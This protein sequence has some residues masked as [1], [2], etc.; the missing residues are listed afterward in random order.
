MTPQTGAPQFLVLTPP[1]TQH[2]QAALHHSGTA[3]SETRTYQLSFIAA[4]KIQFDSHVNLLGVLLPQKSLSILGM[5]NMSVSHWG[6]ANAWDSMCSITH[7]HHSGDFSRSPQLYSLR[8]AACLISTPIVT[9]C[10]IGSNA[11]SHHY[12]P[13][14]QHQW[15]WL[16]TT[17][18]PSLTFFSQGAM[19][20]S[21]LFVFLKSFHLNTSYANIYW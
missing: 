8:W 5:L 3:V 17:W 4:A 7:R 18:V 19:Y 6:T 14:R 11:F 10:Q 1:I 9:Y 2:L 15:G 21:F 16:Y 12:I 20:H 13:L